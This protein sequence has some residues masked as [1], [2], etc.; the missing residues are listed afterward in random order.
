MNWNGPHPINQILGVQ[1]LLEGFWL[2]LRRSFPDFKRRVDVFLGGCA[3]G[4]EYVTGMGHF[5]GTFRH[6][7]LCIP[8]TRQRADLHFGQ[9]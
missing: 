6:D 7:W 4:E 5:T 9:Q 1:G 3:D 2:P 8:A